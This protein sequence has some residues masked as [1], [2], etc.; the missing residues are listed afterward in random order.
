MGGSAAGGMSSSTRKAYA[1]V[2][3]QK[4]PRPRGD[5]GFTFDFESEYPDH[6]DALVITACIANA[7]IR[8]IMIDTGSSTDILYLDAFHK[9]RMTNRDLAPMTSTLTGFTGDAIT[10]VGVVTLVI[11]GDEPRTKTLMVQF[12]V[13]D[14][15][16]AYSVIIGAPT[17]NKLR[18]F[19][20][21]YHRS[22][23][24]PTSTSP[25]EIKS[26]P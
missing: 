15:P 7:C 23:K 18:A 5:P 22:M 21:T 12:M 16:S 9:L 17:L 24:F 10:P 20:S 13:V 1:R 8:C 14:L 2:E 4:R 3:V 19:V 26:D 6:D 11:F 25:G